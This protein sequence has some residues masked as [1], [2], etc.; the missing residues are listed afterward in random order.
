MTNDQALYDQ[1]FHAWTEQQARLP[2]SGQVDEAD[3][4]LIVE[5]IETSGASERR[6]LEN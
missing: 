3:L 1:N 2:R 6:E 4:M 5:E